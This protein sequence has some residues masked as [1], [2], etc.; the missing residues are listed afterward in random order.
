MVWSMARNYHAVLGR[1]KAIFVPSW[2]FFISWNWVSLMTAP[3]WDKS[4]NINGKLLILAK[5]DQLLKLLR[6][7]SWQRS[8]PIYPIACF[9]KFE[10]KL[11]WNNLL[12]LH[13]CCRME[14]PA[15][16]THF[17]VKTGHK[18]CRILLSGWLEHIHK[19]NAGK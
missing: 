7:V 13:K 1:R 9:G 11:I 17:Q 5:L 3:W 14:W 8:R 4:M 6:R 10:I 18:G 16:K 19:T 15:Q 2:A 12:T